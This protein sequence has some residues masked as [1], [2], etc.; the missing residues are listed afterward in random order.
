MC[1][2]SVCL[3]VPVA[4]MLIEGPRIFPPLAPPSGGA[5]LLS[6]A[7]SGRGV[8]SLAPGGF[9][10]CH[11]DL[12]T[13]PRIPSFRGDPLSLQAPPS[14]SEPGDYPGPS[15]SL[16]SRATVRHMAN[17]PVLSRTDRFCVQATG[18][19]TESRQAQSRLSC[20]VQPLRVGLH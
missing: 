9:A 17:G 12:L 15:L 4:V 1:S 8:A 3:S 10:P 5:R 14:L 19:R 20:S 11:S 7:P 13:P 16:G 2:G 18:A 6:A